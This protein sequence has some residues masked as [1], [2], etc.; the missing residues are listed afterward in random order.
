MLERLAVNMIIEFDK[1]NRYER[2][3]LTLANPNRQEIGQ[4]G[5]YIDLNVTLNFN[6]VSE[7]SFEYPELCENGEKSN[8]YD[9]IKPK[10]VIRTEQ[11]GYFII[12]KCDETKEGVVN[13]LNITVT[14]A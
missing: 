6:A 1:F 8:L 9:Q 2:P 11:L 14:S 10:K 12:T 13:K 4:L 5:S 3:I 7:I